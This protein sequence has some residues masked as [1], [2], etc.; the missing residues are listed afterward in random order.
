METVEERK[1]AGAPPAFPPAAQLMQLTTG[2]MVSQAVAVAAR[3]G[4][5]DALATGPRTCEEIAAAVNA[6][7]GALHR[8]LRAI[9]DCGVVSD[10]ENGR[11]ALNPV[12]ELLRSD[13]P[14]SLRAWATM[15]GMPFHRD[16]WTD[17]YT[18]VQTG[19]PA[20]ERV[21]GADLF[22]YLA[23]HPEDAAIFDGAMT[24]MAMAIQSGVVRTYDFSRCA[25]VVDVGGG[26]GA[27]LA[28]IL[29]ANPD[30]HGMLLDTPSVTEEARA[31]LRRAGVEDRSRIVEGDFF[32]GVP[33]GGD[34]YI[35]SNIL[36][37]WEDETARRILRN[38]R[39]AMAEGTGLLIVEHVLPETAV[40]SVAK[41]VDLEMLA[42]TGGRQRTPG[43]FA[44]LLAGTGFRLTEAVPSTMDAPASYVEAVAI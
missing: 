36:H 26:R 11:F 29:S 25:E 43:E 8:L 34:L 19:E 17:L 20:F 24:S 23:T 39:S 10:L 31:T 12:G 30:L 27:L 35:L 7:A 42:V 41:L 6:D 2:T 1:T 9:A 32:S 15:T 21:H 4:V 14:G 37:D 22:G 18:S 13:V 38:C 40:P 28:A 44:A 33:A 5:A 3:L 16:A